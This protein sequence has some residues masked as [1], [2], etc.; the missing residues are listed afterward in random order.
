MGC[1]GGS[2]K[3]GLMYIVAALIFVIAG[4]MAVMRLQLA[5]PNNHVGGAGNV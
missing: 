2:Q 3:L 1:N 4:S 5:V